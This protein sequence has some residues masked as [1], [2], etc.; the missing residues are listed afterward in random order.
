MGLECSI[1]PRR[2]RY[3]RGFCMDFLYKLAHDPG[4]AFQD[5]EKVGRLYEYHPVGRLGSR[6]DCF[7]TEY[8]CYFLMKMHQNGETAYVSP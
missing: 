2:Y 4:Q 8:G 3:R 7:S 6:V 1:E 5:K